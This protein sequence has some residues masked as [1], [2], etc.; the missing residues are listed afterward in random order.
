MPSH[1]SRARRRLDTPLLE[2]FEPA[3]YNEA[4][5]LFFERSLGKNP[6]ALLLAGL[7]RGVNPRAVEE[8]LGSI[9][10]YIQLENADPTMRWCGPAAIKEAIATYRQ[11]TQQSA[12][13]R[14]RIRVA[15]PSMYAWTARGEGIHGAVGSDSQ[16]VRTVIQPGGVRKSLSVVLN[17]A[18][19]AA[20]LQDAVFV[21]DFATEAPEHQTLIESRDKGQLECPVCHWV[22]NY[23][24]ED[25]R[26]R[27]NAET[28]MRSHLRNVR[29]QRSE[30]R[31]LYAKLY[32]GSSSEPVATLATQSA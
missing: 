25:H 3:K 4:E 28:G 31:A 15:H 8:V 16:F 17:R 6:R 7:P 22:T 9:Y 14:D 18:P 2:V 11:W 26:T 23:D 13:L 29:K 27:R 12:L 20:E 1:L 10:E 5:L 24:P 30:H 19:L 21:P 32:H